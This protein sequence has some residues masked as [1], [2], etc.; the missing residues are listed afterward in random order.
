MTSLPTLPAGVR[1]D[2]T[3]SAAGRPLRPGIVFDRDG[4]VIVEEHY[5]SDPARVALEAGC[6]A[7]LRAVTAAGWGCGVATN[8]AGIARGYF[9]WAAYEAVAQR[10]TEALAEHQC[11]VEATI[12]CGYHP[13]HGEQ[14]PD[15]DFWRKPGPGM[16]LY[17]VEH[18]ALDPAQSWMIGDKAGDLKSAKA[19]GL[20]GGIHLLTGHGRDE[21]ERDKALALADDS[22]YV[23]ATDS[24]VSCLPLFDP[25]AGF[26]P[27]TK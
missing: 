8:Q 14:T 20:R 17:L 25:V 27:A 15:A 3:A 11:A 1:S 10:I 4:V 5:L 6:P 12:A 21:G 7:F 24:L 26:S 13:K 9:D 19:A 22:F 2:L 18:L 23:I 16:V